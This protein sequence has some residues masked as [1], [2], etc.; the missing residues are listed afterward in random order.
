[1]TSTLGTTHTSTTG[2]GVGSIGAGTYGRVVLTIKSAH[3]LNDKVAPTR[4]AS[5]C[6][7]PPRAPSRSLVR[8][9]DAE[10][11]TA[12]VKNAGE[13]CVW[14]E[15]FRFNNVAPD[16]L[17]YFKVYDHNRLMKDQFMGE[18]TLSLRQ[19]FEE[20]RLETRVP[21]AS[22]TG[23]KDAGEVWV[24][25]RMEE[26]GAPGTAAAPGMATGVGAA[27]PGAPG[28]AA[29]GV[30]APGVAAGMGA[31]GMAAG[32]GAYAETGKAYAGEREGLAGRE[33]LA[34]REAGYGE[35]ERYESREAAVPAS[36]VVETTAP[37]AATVIAPV[38]RET[39]VAGEAVRTGR[40]EVCGQEY[41]T[42]VEDR[43]I[44]KERVTYV[45]EHR[46][47]EKEFVVET[48]ATGV[49]REVA[50]GRVQES[51]GTQ[52]RVVE[53]ALPRAPC[54]FS[55]A[56]SERQEQ[57]QPCAAPQQAED[58]CCSAA[59][60]AAPAPAALPGLVHRLLVA[61]SPTDAY[62]LLLAAALGGW[63]LLGAAAA[64]AAAVGDGAC[65]AHAAWHAPV[66]ADLAENEDFWGNVLR[67]V[68]YF[69]SVLLGTAYVAVK[70]ILE[71][72]KRPT[73]AVLVVAG[74]GGLFFFVSFVV[75]GMLGITEPLDYE[76]SSIVTPMLLLAPPALRG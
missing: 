34:E 30:A 47:V 51:M 45:K 62:L 33:G 65:A 52:S 42:K 38:A 4:C 14:D 67:Y 5:L 31:G 16:D 40:E 26:G 28:V 73:T 2:T 10:I 59:A 63:A 66:L 9:G 19:V 7:L 6:T 64:A 23:I 25:L 44:V 41:F 39:A 68:T 37:A 48:R 20:G 35:R 29:P 36:R 70:P 53:E 18:G 60:E 11:Q 57:Q 72:L 74:L 69:F 12:H 54:E 61:A 1:M 55:R 50:E 24:A 46:P 71:L 3:N 43:P 76:P 15:S 22:R 32:E 56:L 8:C 27:V 75:R 21:L 58:A 17:I 49:E 13:Q